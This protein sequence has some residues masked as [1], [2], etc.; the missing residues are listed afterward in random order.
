[1]ETCSGCGAQIQGG[2]VLYTPAAKI[3]CPAC[4]DKAAGDSSS[5]RS[6]VTGL[7]AAGLGAGIIPFFMS[8][9][10]SSSTSVNGQIVSS[11]SRDY[12]A[13]VF[14][15][16][17]AMFGA[18]AAAGAVR[19]KLGTTALAIRFAVIGLGGYQIAHGFGAI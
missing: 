2:D 13:L 15:V 16:A 18:I 19:S 17:A 5:G 1:M 4:F 8:V 14:G 12:I 3:V 11:S 6:S 9:T 7:V 10:S